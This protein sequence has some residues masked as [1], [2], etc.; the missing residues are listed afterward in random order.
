MRI[1]V[2]GKGGQ[3]GRSIQDLVVST[4]QND[5]FIFTGRK[6]LDLS[7]ENSIDRYFRANDGF[8]V[9]VNCAAYTAV[10]KAEGE[11]ELAD[12]INHLAVKKMAEIAIKQKAKLIHIS[13][14]YVFDGESDEPY[15]EVSKVNP[16]NSYGKT[17]LAGEFAIR[18]LM[19]INAIIIRTSWVYSEYGNNFVKTMLELDKEKSEINVVADQIGSPT[20]AANLARVVLAIL[21][22]KNYRC[23]KNKTEVYHYSNKG[24]VSWYDFAKEIFRLKE[25]KCL[26]HPMS[27]TQ[28]P[29]IARRPKNTLMSADKIIKEFDVDIESWR[30]SLRRF[31]C[32]YSMDSVERS[33][34]L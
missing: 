26:V 6:E 34:K 10:D 5:D 15:T 19:P 1:L 32:N 28:Y 23:K 3:L 20:Y 11:Q 24:R 33:D 22:K 17:K 30:S 14:D 29:T 25:S 31:L 16:I 18:E 4:E 9:V 7:N 21:N 12:Q 2:T 13:T 8:D 27:T